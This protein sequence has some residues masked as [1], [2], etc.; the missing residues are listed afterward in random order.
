M[1]KNIN[2]TALAAIML[3]LV[4][5]GNLFL[6]RNASAEDGNKKEKVE[7]TFNPYVMDAGEDLQIRIAYFDDMA[8]ET[9]WTAT[10]QEIEWQEDQSRYAVRFEG[11]HYWSVYYV[12]VR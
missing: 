2:W 6:N 10:I 9:D 11:D 1:K 4:V 7:S 5:L 12:N 3:V 8:K